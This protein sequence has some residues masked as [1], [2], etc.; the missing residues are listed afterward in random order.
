MNQYPKHL[1]IGTALVLIGVV[2]LLARLDVLRWEWWVA[3]W[4]LVAA[5]GA[6]K[7]VQGISGRRPGKVFWGTVLLL[8]GGAQVLSHAGLMNDLPH[9]LTPF[10]LP[11]LLT[12]VGIAFLAMFLVNPKEWQILV[13]A[14]GFLGIGTV[15][16][17]ADLGTFSREEVVH[18]V[19]NYWPLGLIVFGTAL[20]LRRRSV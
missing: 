1:W 11:L 17:L 20:L 19:R 13:P 6:V 4:V 5:L 7:I 8:I 3:I 9:Y 12:I 10:S 16:I 18:A 2:M 15:M 14:L